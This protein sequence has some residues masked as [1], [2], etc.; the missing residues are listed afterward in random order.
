MILQ[1]NKIIPL[2]GISH[3]MTI[4]DMGSSIGFWAK[5][6]GQIV[7]PAGKV[8]AVDFHPEI[9]DRLNHDVT[10]HGIQ[11]I[12]GITGDVHKLG[13]LALKKDSCDIVL[14]VR[15]AGVID[16]ELENRIPELLAF[17]KPGGKLVVI[18]H[19]EHRDALD[20]IFAANGSHMKSTE[21]TQIGEQTENH[22]C[23]FF[24]ERK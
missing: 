10:E 7:G 6:L 8:I 21:I 11:N 22:F 9:I 5:P 15:M 1:P 17:T 2:L 19:S 24:V 20:K 16:D 14:L 13:D 12:H 3:G 18:D 4:L 23:G